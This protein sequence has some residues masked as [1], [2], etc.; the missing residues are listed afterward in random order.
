MLNVGARLGP[1]E[2]VSPLGAGGMGEVYRARD[3]RLER[4]VAIKILP[5]EFA[6]DPDLRAR[7][8]RE[9][10]AIAAL[11]HPHICALYDVGDHDGTL[12]LVMQYLDG[13]TLE[14][15]LTR[16]KGPLPIDQALTIAIEI[17]EALD[18]AHRAG[19]THRDLKPANIML[20]RSGGASAPP[21]AK[22]L[23]FGLAKLRGPASPISMSG[24]TRLA[25]ATPN[26][27]HGT[28]LGT[29]HYM[30][31]EQVEGREADA[32]AD[33]WALGV[34]LYEMLTGIRPFEGTSPASVIGA[35]LRDDPQPV[36]R[37]QPLAPASLD[38][39]VAKC[40]ARDP[41]QRWQ[42]VA[43]A[44]TTLEW[45]ARGRDLQ[46]AP[47]ATGG[48][49]RWRAMAAAALLVAAAATL[50]W[51]EAASG[52][53]TDAV[54]VRTSVL[55]PPDARFV[56]PLA[57][58]IAPQLALSPDGRRLAC[59]AAER[60]RRPMLWIRNLDTL[61][62]QAVAGTEDAQY[63]FWSPDGRSIAVFAQGRLRTIDLSDPRNAP[64][65]LTDVLFDL[66][67]GSWS[68]DG[69]IIFA[70]G[71]QSPIY[72]VPAGG[73]APT[74]VTR[75]DASRKERSHRFPSF[76]PDGR[77]F[78]YV[79]RGE[80]PEYRG[81]YVAS[82]DSTDAKRVVE[83]T[84]WGVQYVEPGYVVFLRGTDL[85]AQP[86]DA[87]RLTTT[88][89]AV[90]IAESVGATSVSYA[91]FSASRNGVLAYGNQLRLPG[92]LRWFDRSG[93][94]QGVVAP[95]GEYV[96]FELSHDERTLAFSRIDPQPNTSDVWLLDLPRGVTTRLTT[97]RLTDASAH[98]SPND[99]RLAFR[100]NRLG[101]SDVYMKRASGAGPEELVLNTNGSLVLN[102]WSR[103]GRYLVYTNTAAADGYTIMMW[104]LPGD[105][106]PSV[107]VS[108][109][110]NGF[111]ASTARFSPDTKWIAYV[112]N[113][114]G[115]EEVYVQPFPSTGDKLKI[116]RDGGW[117]PQ[118]RGDGKELFYLS[119]RGKLMSVALSVS[120]TRLDASPPVPL[121]DVHVPLLDVFRTNYGVARN[122]QRF[123]V[124]TVTESLPP[125]S[126]SVVTNW[127]TS[128][129]K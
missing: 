62:P 114:S 45:I 47:A 123:L 89:P 115:A 26:T 107:V 106:K 97:E 126:I 118:W 72:R 9:A 6:S 46:S 113:E 68:A 48:Q 108:A 109:Q 69:T 120:G 33:I 61:A 30:A 102:D 7:F 105:A 116:S 63:P 100:S 84:D 49:K 96:D 18:K 86:F 111:N 71:A 98:W 19:I 119:P 13:E 55:P 101:S 57:T 14:Q 70:H 44:A 1:Y 16:T 43:D 41:D 91:A 21:T 37:L 2:I 50:G 77:H 110:A 74:P 12:Y 28:I 103:D 15:R 124:N 23:D 80:L 53:R 82:L 11:D 17:A 29:V 95:L 79:V 34:L 5:A 56:G 76:L 35:I 121:F 20:V 127:T 59:I 31:P 85:F 66:R 67:G 87:K 129:R 94:S 99:D 39:F 64:T 60:D 125:S 92:E 128:V 93:V 42:S 4:T 36:S 54:S 75:L 73:G 38:L 112:S 32:R 58:V 3:T 8:E 40:L 122:G 88:G 83:N 10:R 78:F 27:A 65:V 104:P 81:A 24:M 117:E 22:L 25:T 52:S 90:S 51:Y